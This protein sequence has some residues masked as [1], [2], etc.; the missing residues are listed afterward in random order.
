M[1]KEE[2]TFE[3]IKNFVTSHAG[4]MIKDT[5]AETVSMIQKRILDTQRRILRNI[6]VTLLFFVGTVFIL[7]SFIFLIEQYTSLGFG[8]STFILGLIIILISFL[9]MF[10]GELNGKKS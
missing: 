8:W 5:V 2:S 10:R 4:Q 7:I 9:Y 6:F 1:A 3:S